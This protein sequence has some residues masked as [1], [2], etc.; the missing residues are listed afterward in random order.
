MKTKK[1]KKKSSTST[2]HFMQRS[3]AASMAIDIW[4]TQNIAKFETASA[5]FGRERWKSDL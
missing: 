4:F 3:G 1:P 2:S 5:Q